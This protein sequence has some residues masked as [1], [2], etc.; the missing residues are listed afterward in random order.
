MITAMQVFTFISLFQVNG[1]PAHFE[2]SHNATIISEAIAQAVNEEQ[3]APITDSY[4]HDAAL[5]V[6]YA[7]YESGLRTCVKGDGGKSIGTFQIQGLDSIACN[8]ILAARAWIRIA[9]DAQAMCSDNSIETNLAALASGFCD[10]GLKLV[11][12]RY[13][14]YQELVEAYNE[15]EFELTME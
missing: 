13:E 7:I 4:E 6:V 3:D 2:K 9:K 12:H 1:H 8:P 5:M 14:V 15:R 11:Q 10:R